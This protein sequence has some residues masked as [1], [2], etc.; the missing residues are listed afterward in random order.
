[1]KTR[2]DVEMLLCEPEFFT[3]EYEI[4]P[5]MN[6]DD[7]VD[8]KLAWRQW[9]HLRDTLVNLGVQIHLLDP[10][11]GLPDIVFTG[12]GGVVL[13]NRFVSSSFRPKERRPEAECFRKWFSDH[14][15]AVELL[16]EGVFFEGLGDIVLFGRKAIAAYGQR[17]SRD[18]LDHIRAKFPEF[19]WIAELE[20]VSPR[21]FHLGVA[22]SLLDEKTGMYVPEAFSDESRA[23]IQALEQEMIPLGDEDAR[24]FALNAIVVGRNLVVNYCSSQLQADLESRGFNVI[25]CDVSEFVKSGGGTRCLVLPF[26]TLPQ[27]VG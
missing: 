25:V 16:P 19:E 7:P 9:R 23:A 11:K 3:V 2:S 14:G 18:A 21:Y 1:M 24:G 10:V 15:F 22:L 6:V 12:D 4:N 27:G 26:A 20:L 17:T 13:G 5:W 8:T